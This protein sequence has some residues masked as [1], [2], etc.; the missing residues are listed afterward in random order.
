VHRPLPEGFDRP[1]SEGSGDV[2]AAVDEDVASTHVAHHPGNVERSL[3]VMLTPS[4][5]TMTALSSGK[6][7]L[8]WPPTPSSGRPMS[9]IHTP[10]AVCYWTEP[11]I[12]SFWAPAHISPEGVVKPVRDVA[13]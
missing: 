9:A 11:P 12:N 10:A 13:D 8:W 7:P 2:A 6:A 4:M 5:V 3:S 1:A